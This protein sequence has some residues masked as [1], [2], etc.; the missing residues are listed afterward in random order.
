M[1]RLISWQAPNTGLNLT[2]KATDDDDHDDDCHKMITIINH[3]LY[4]TGTSRYVGTLSNLSAKSWPSQVPSCY[5]DDE[6]VN[7][8]TKPNTCHTASRARS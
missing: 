1:S 6:N 8:D 5:F 3:D 2:S 4:S 7:Y